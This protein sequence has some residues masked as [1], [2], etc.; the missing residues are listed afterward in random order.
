MEV[1]V[2]VPGG[3]VVD[4]DVDALDV[5]SAAEDVGGD[6][7][8]LLEGLELLVAAD[9]LGLGQARV[10]RDRGEVALAQEG[11]ELGRARD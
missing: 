10:D 7:D 4:D 3:V 9:A 8:A 6:E 1:R 5:D 2:G 11:V